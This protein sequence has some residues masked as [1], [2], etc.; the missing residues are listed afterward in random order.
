[1]HIRGRK[2]LAHALLD[3]QRR[4]LRAENSPMPMS[5]AD[6]CLLNVSVKGKATGPTLMLSNS[7]GCIMRM[8]EPQMKALGQI[9]A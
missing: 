8:W 1:M 9:F 5:D 6:G 3:W 7:L 4:K 2:N